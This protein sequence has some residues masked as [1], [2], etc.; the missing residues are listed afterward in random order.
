MGVSVVVTSGKGGTG[1]TSFTGGVGSCLAALRQK[2]LCI[3]MDVGLRNL[4][5]TLGLTDR[6]VMDFTDVLAGRCTLDLAAVP[7]PDIQGLYL[8]TAP[9]TLEPGV[10][11][12]GVKAL[13]DR[14]KEE[15][16]FVLMD[17]PAGLGDGFRLA[18]GAADRG[19]VVSTTDP[20]ALRDA[21]RT[22]ME[23]TPSMATLHLVM[24]RVRPKMI[25]QLH[26]N[27]D[28]AMNTAGLPLLG[29]IPEDPKVTLAAGIGKPLILT[30]HRGAAVAYLNIAKRLMGRSVPLM[31]T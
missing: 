20:S 31:L 10:T 26:T 29:V 21:Q 13:V 6:A 3:D 2:V 4:D 30:A 8:L 27:L 19:V 17:S 23:L 16:D 25:R 5:I 18:A 12:E 9:M 11:A 1:K 22:V 24:N 28:E 7:H 15:Y 14:A